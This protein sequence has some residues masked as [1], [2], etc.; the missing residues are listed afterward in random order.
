M[1]PAPPVTAPAPAL[2]GTDQTEMPPDDRNEKLTAKQVIELLSHISPDD[3]DDWMMFGH[4]LKTI[5]DWVGGEEAAFQIWDQWCR[6]WKLYQERA[7]CPPEIQVADG[8]QCA[9][10]VPYRPSQKACEG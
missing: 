9:I 10:A 3:Y 1:R 5:L 6:K 2:P 4:V 8:I 7:S